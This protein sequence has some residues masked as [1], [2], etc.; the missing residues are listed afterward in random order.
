MKFSE[1]IPC[2]DRNLIY[3]LKIKVNLT[4]MEHY[5]RHCPP[6]ERRY[7]CLIPLPIGYKVCLFNIVY[8]EFNLHLLQL[9]LMYITLFNIR[10]LSGGLQAEMRYGKQIYRILTL[11]RR[12][13]IRIGW[14]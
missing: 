14:L 8:A 9:E 5:E 2:L 7:N 10:S 1:L 4:L 6:P 11:H 12:N 3:Q 13:Q